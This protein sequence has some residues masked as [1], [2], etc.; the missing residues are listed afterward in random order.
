MLSKSINKIIFSLFTLTLI[1]VGLFFVIAYGWLGIHDGPGK[2]TNQ[3]IPKEIIKERT[4]IQTQTATNIN[5][6]N[7]KQI[8]FGDLHAHTTLSF[9]AFLGSLPML[10]GEGSHPLADACDF[11]RFC[12]ALDF[13]SIN[14]HAE[15][16]T[17]RRWS[18]TVS[19]IQQCNA[20]GG[21]GPNPDTVAFLGWEW[22]QMGAT[23]DTHFGHKNVIFRDIET[24][25]VPKR[26][27]HSGGIANSA[28]RGLPLRNGPILFALDPN[29]RMLDFNL[30]LHELRQSKECELGKSVWELSSDCREGAETPAELFS[31]LDDWGFESMVIP[32]GT[33]WGFYT[34]PASEFNKQLIGDNFD[35]NRQALLEVFSGHG[36]SEEYRDFRATVMNDKQQPICPA[37]SDDYLP[38]CHRA[39][40]IIEDRCLA[41]GESPYECQKRAATARQDYVNAGTGGHLTVRGEG[42]EDWLD[43]GQCK[44]CYIPAFNY[45][46]GG[47][48]QYIMAQTNFDDPENP[49][50]FRFG[51]MAS[52]DNHSA[53]P[54]TG[55]KEFSRRGMTESVLGPATKTAERAFRFNDGEPIASSD[56]I[57]V[58]SDLMI[59]RED[60]N[61]IKTTSKVRRLDIVPL[62]ITER[63]RQASFFTT[64]GLMAV[65][66][67]GRDRNSIW[68]SMQKKAVYGTSGDR[69]LLWFNTKNNG[70]NASVSM[71]D[72]V[73][74][75]SAPEFE[76]RAVG[77]FEQKPGCPDYT[78]NALTPERLENLCRGECYNPS[79]TR[80]LITRIEVIRIL[81]QITP[82]E[83]IS[84]LIQDP[85]KTFDCKADPDG[86]EVNFID[87]E[88]PSLGRD[89]VYYVRAI[90]SPSLAVNA[91]NLRCEYDSEGNCKKVNLCYGDRRGDMNDDC[92]AVNEERAWSSPI[93]VDWDNDRTQA[94]LN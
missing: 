48:A 49:R 22:T 10:Q 64:G 44:D 8:L 94:S 78:Y 59:G 9:D 92:L 47:A 72:E 60:L 73:A 90:E 56:N 55:Y 80:K 85:W 66:S 14:D 1:A 77:A 2:I 82:N 57:D 74:M 45:R 20:V 23:P 32:H 67:N 42:P 76:V 15:A 69:I 17:P 38:S 37:P 89:A 81:P 83:D 4:Q 5:A 34:P 3:M 21:N 54:G 84:G 33:T 70:I 93:F 63:E 88:Y 46:P 36:N 52:S 35:P 19:S 31:K 86:C 87:E 50:R 43:S 24:E 18:E 12:S 13:W 29:Q 91:E 58:G 7:T 65:H 41:I 62:M 71:G 51:F 25:K 39:G 28:L 68:D 30:Y 27:I 11:A 79:D 16:S 26:P 75:S 40:Q 53:R 61:L 6:D